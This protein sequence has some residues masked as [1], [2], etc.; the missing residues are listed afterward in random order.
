MRENNSSLVVMVYLFFI[1]FCFFAPMLEYID[2]ESLDLP[3][4]HARITDVD[5]TAKVLDESGK[6][7]TCSCY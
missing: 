5:Y 2:F 1:F 3:W 6:R 4:D 7:R